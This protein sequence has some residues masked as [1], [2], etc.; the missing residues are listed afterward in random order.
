MSDTASLSAGA[1]IDPRRSTFISVFGPKGSGK[2]HLAARFFQT[3]PLD[4]IAIDPTGDAQVGDDVERLTDPL[5]M[6]WPMHGADE[7]ISWQYVPDPGAA[8]WADDMDRALGLAVRAGRPVLA[9]IDEI[10][11]LTR[12]NKTPSN[13]R[14]A[15]HQGRHFKLSLLMCGPRPV[16]VDPLVLG[17]ADFLYLF[18]IVHPLDRKRLAEVIGWKPV[19]LDAALDGLGQYE[20]LRWDTTNRE[21]AHFP[22]IPAQLP[23]PTRPRRRDSLIAD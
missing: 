15:L 17:N 9:W 22:P 1:R 19:E 2:S 6:R 7:R 18:A 21:M 12:A 11:E 20:Y 3:W 10:G 23:R 14:R 4:R 13:M 16:D 5:P 8:T